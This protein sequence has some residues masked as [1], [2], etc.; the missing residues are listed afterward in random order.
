[1]GI[2]LVPTIFGAGIYQINIVANTILASMLE[3]GS[4]SMLYY[5]DRIVQLPLGVFGVSL[6]VA[7]LPAVSSLL[8]KKDVSGAAKAVRETFGLTWFIAVPSS[9]GLMI[10]AEPIV[11]LLFGRG[12]FGLQEVIVTSWALQAYAAGL[13]AFC[14]VRTLVSAFYSL[15]DTKTPVIAGTVSVAGNIIL[16]IVLMR[17]W[18]LVGLALA[19]SLASWINLFI[20]ALRLKTRLPWG[21]GLWPSLGRTLALSTFLGLLVWFTHGWGPWAVFLI[22]VWGILYGLGSVVLAM[23]EGRML[24]EFFKKK[25]AK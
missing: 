7:S 4:I 25:K 15:E 10:I 5:A 11:D 2:L 18:G 14:G 13:P 22:P 17:I 16:G 12:K 9:V 8:A 3:K 1:V 6:A 20:L 24:L 19:T 23:P 21:L